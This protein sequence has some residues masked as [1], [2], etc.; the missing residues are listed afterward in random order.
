MHEFVFDL[1]NES[2]DCSFRELILF[3][4]VSAA[5][6]GGVRFSLRSPRIN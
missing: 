1:I 4:H 5:G 2:L 6:V 3:P